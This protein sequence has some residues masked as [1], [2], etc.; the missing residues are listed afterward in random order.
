MSEF[1]EPSEEEVDFFDRALLPGDEDQ[2]VSAVT[3]T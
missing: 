2:P 3:A 1:V